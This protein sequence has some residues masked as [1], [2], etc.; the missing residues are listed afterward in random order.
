MHKLLW[1]P[2]AVTARREL[3][4]SGL[5][6]APAVADKPPGASRPIGCES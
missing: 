2:I 3:A 1:T 6:D 4:T 5:A